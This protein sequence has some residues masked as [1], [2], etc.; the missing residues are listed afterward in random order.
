L[1]NIVRGEKALRTYKV[2]V[3]KG[4]SVRVDVPAA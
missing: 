3:N 4:G 1:L 2:K